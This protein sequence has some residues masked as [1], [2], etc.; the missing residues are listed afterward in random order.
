MFLIIRQEAAT[1]TTE[2][3]NQNA[4]RK[5]RSKLVKSPWQQLLPLVPET[6]SSP[7]AVARSHPPVRRQEFGF[8]E[9]RKGAGLGAGR[10]EPPA[11][12]VWIDQGR[13]SARKEA[14]ARSQ[15]LASF[16]VALTRPG[17]RRRS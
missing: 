2:E 16:A 6:K 13:E 8:K 12:L 3:E 9:A 1:N 10:A 15:Q 4:S 5:L 14:E 17:R 7:L 11:G